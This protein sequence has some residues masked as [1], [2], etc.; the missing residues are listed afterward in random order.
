MSVVVKYKGE[1]ILSLNTDGEEAL[2][3]EGQYCEADII[4]ENTQDG[5]VGG[6]Y[7]IEVVDDGNGGQILNITDADGGGSGDVYVNPNVIHHE[8]VTLNTDYNGNIVELMNI[9]L[10]L[11]S[12]PEEV[13]RAIAHEPKQFYVQNEWFLAMNC[14][15]FFLGLTNSG[16]R[17]RNEVWSATPV[18]ASYDAVAFVGDKFDVYTSSAEAI[19][20]T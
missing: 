1:E 11:T 7:N 10:A 20:P 14:S 3:T 16:W 4:I 8:I 6:D 12:H 19:L 18:N 13:C 5:D 2:A 9:L 17:Y 15:N